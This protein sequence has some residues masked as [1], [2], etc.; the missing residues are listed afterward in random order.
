M[1]KLPNVAF[2]GL[3]RMGRP[4]AARLVAAGYALQVH[5]KSGGKRLAGA[6]AF[7]SSREAAAGADL[8]ITMLPDGKAVRAALLGRHGAAGALAAG[9]IVIDMSSCHPAGTQALGR[10]LAERGIELLDAPVSGRV[11]GARS[12][13]LSIMAG[14]RAAALKRARPVLAVLGQRIFHA[15]PLGAGHAVKALNNY[16]AAAGTL[17][18]FEAVIVGRAFGLDPALMTDIFNASAGR[19]STTEN[20]VRQHVLS[21]AFASGFQLALMAK[22][23]GIAAELARSLGVEAPLTLKARQVWRAAERALPSGA[24]HTE[25]YRYLEALK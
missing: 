21:G 13:T 1:K 22:D 8:L 3:G 16:I 12:G 5:D 2:I 4:M 7:A 25:V 9:G 11:D 6:R 15:G 19:N 10:E 14:G 17:A 18:A 24:D 23:V 20:K